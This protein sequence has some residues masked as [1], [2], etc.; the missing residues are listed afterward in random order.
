MR[1]HSCPPPRRVVHCLPAV[2]WLRVKVRV[3]ADALSEAGV[4][5]AV[6][7]RR[8]EAR[9]GTQLTRRLQTRRY[10]IDNAVCGCW[11]NEVELLV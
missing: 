7:L 8:T 3:M 1:A 9:A 11:L 2:G 10:M 4:R 5:T 6:R